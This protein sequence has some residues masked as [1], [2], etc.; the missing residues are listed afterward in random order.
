[1]VLNSHF[2]HSWLPPY[3]NVLQDGQLGVRCFFVLSGLLITHLLLKEASRRDG[4]VSIRNF[5]IRRI[6]RIV[7]AYFCFLGVMLVQQSMGNVALTFD[8]WLSLF[9]F[10]ANFH[11]T[12][13]DWTVFHLWTLSIE[14]QF[15]LF[16][17]LILLVLRPWE[18]PKAIFCFVVVLIC[19][20]VGYRLAAGVIRFWLTESELAALAEQNKFWAIL[21]VAKLHIGWAFQGGATFNY[22]DC[23]GIGC[24][25]AA[26]LFRFSKLFDTLS[27]PALIILACVAILFLAVPSGMTTEI[28]WLRGITYLFGYTVQAIG[29]ALL[30]LLS[31][32]KPQFFLGRMMAARPIVW[33]GVISYSI[34]LWQQPFTILWLPA[35]PVALKILAIF[36]V[37][38]LSY[39]FIER[40][41][42]SLKPGHLGAS[43][44]KASPSN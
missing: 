28:R 39:Y 25:A 14:Q 22:L 11:L 41:F 19:F 7:P 43:R 13:N 29:C 18:T 37:A 15:Y 36:V 34:Y 26:V 27:K 31:V 10:T 1:M 17:P 40:P 12:L 9:T 4:A 24:A 8:N 38:S 3:L 35:S 16:W 6:L 21:L 5:Y 42:N 44:L 33:V 23:L 30:L 20:V 2:G 32:T